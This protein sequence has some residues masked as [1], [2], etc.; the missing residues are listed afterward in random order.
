MSD[1][2][3]E[4]TTTSAALKRRNNT[5]TNYNETYFPLPPTIYPQ[6]TPI[7]AKRS[8]KT[9]SDLSDERAFLLKLKQEWEG[10]LSDIQIDSQFLK[11]MKDVSKAEIGDTKPL[12]AKEEKEPTP[13]LQLSREVSPAP[14]L[15]PSPSPSPAPA[16]APETN[17]SDL[18]ALRKLREVYPDTETEVEEEDDDYYNDD[19]EEEDEERARIALNLMLQE[20]GDVL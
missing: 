16:P 15:S 20:F 1:S 6:G 8:R 19:D 10:Q 7:T 5:E 4:L 11:K 18:S 3:P 9:Y 2:A 14:D 13:P 12:F 17:T